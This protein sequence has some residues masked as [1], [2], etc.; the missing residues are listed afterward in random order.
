MQQS[1]LLEFLRTF[2]PRQLTRFREFL[3]SPYFNKSAELLEF[4]DRIAPY[5]PG[6]D[7][8]ALAKDALL[9]AAAGGKPLTE[10]RL[11]YLMNQLLGLAETF[12]AVETFRNDPLAER[13]SLV[14]A[15]SPGHSPRHYRSVQEKAA[16]ALEQ[17]P[18]RN[19]HFFAE[20][21]RLKALQYWRFDTDQQQLNQDLQ[22]A[23][24][25]L[26]A[27]FWVEKL[28]ICWAMA[29]SENILNLQ[30][31]WGLG[32]WLL[33]YLD[34]QQPA[35]H[36]TAEI[37]R[38]GLRMTQHPEDTAPY[39]QLKI[40]LQHH[41]ASFN[42]HEQRFLYS[43]L[44]NYC[45]RRI[46]RFNDPKFSQE[47]LDINK[48]MLER[49]LLFDK[50]LLS[51]WHYVNLANTALRTGDT[52]WA[53]QFI[54]QYRNR[55]PAGYQD[56][57]YF[58][59]MGQYHYHRGERAQAQV[60]LNQA[61][62]RDVQLAVLVRNLLTRIYYESGE[63]ELLLSFLEAYRVFL[64]RQVLL[65]AQ[66]KQ[67]ARR[68]VDFTRRLAKIDRPEAHLLPKLKAELPAPTGIFHRDWLERQIEQK[69][70]AFTGRG[71]Q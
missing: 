37:Y 19:A 22:P 44:I 63:T 10:K 49:G 32:Q 55:L 14:Q 35:L 60:L 39:Y 56:D 12:A 1:K 11:A 42:E 51:P 64:L 27:F 61:N 20:S 28:R 23:S 40:L 30:Y 58:M 67:Q 50:G 2:S 38:T 29:D 57:L 66:M 47:Y 13:F 25:A 68:F 9:R 26:D 16:L 4:F 54:E 18:F 31:D 46:N 21:Y 43:S 15:I 52:G 71:G 59:A 41:E 33:D 8:P 62:P 17:Y 48:R 5:G 7:D 34:R 70:A 3:E 6:F 53:L 24:D 45:A 36:P 65:S 69:I